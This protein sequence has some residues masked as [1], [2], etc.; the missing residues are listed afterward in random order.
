MEEVQLEDIKISELLQTNVL[1][2]PNEEIERIKKLYNNWTLRD[3]DN[4]KNIKFNERIGS[5]YPTGYR[6]MMSYMN[7]TK[8]H[9]M[10]KEYNKLKDN[11][12]LADAFNIIQSVLRYKVNEKEW[13]KQIKDKDTDKDKEKDEIACGCPICKGDCWGNGMCEECIDGATGSCHWCVDCKESHKDGIPKECPNYSDLDES[14]DSDESDKE[15]CSLC[16]TNYFLPD[17]PPMKHNC[18]CDS[19]NMIICENCYKIDEKENKIYCP[20]CYTKES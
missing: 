5:N 14:D 16:G 6:T 20:K 8:G 2:V 3:F 18:Y 19:C 9:G 10:Q 13:Y 15:L 1:Y 11:Q 12:S 4:D 7:M 17:L